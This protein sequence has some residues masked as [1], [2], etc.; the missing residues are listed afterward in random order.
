[1]LQPI[2]GGDFVS[3]AQHSISCNIYIRLCVGVYFF[4]ALYDSLGG[5]RAFFFWKYPKRRAG[6]SV[7]ARLAHVRD[8]QKFISG[9]L[10]VARKLRVWCAYAT[11]PFV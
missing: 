7:I 11:G 8:W 3:T 1:M 2:N 4:V 5:V 6:P 10:H 9:D